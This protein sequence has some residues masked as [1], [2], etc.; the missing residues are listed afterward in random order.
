MLKL[1]QELQELAFPPEEEEAAVAGKKAK[2][3]P[4]AKA[5]AAEKKGAGKKGA[6]KKAS[7]NKKGNKNKKEKKEKKGKKA[8]K[9]ESTTP[10][11]K[12]TR[13]PAEPT[14]PVEVV[15]NPITSVLL[16]PQRALVRARDKTFEAYCEQFRQSAQ[17]VHQRFAAVVEGEKVW[18][19]NWAQM[20][21]LL[22]NSSDF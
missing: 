3:S 12:K 11:K 19:S 9:K 13:A 21:E 2:G 6:G 20:V 7:K 18:A 10:P 5:A 8:I 16:P 1:P 4:K 14:E 17:E 15:S 22:K